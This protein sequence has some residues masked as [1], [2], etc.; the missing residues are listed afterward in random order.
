[1][2]ALSTRTTVTLVLTLVL[3]FFGWH[4]EAHATTSGFLAVSAVTQGEIR[5]NTT[6]KGREGLMRVVAISPELKT[7][8][9]ATTGEATAPHRHRPLRLTI[10]VDNSMPLLMKALVDNELLT[11]VTVRMFAPDRTG[12]ETNHYSIKL[13]NA[14]ITRFA[15]DSNPRDPE[16]RGLDYLH[17]ELTYETIELVWEAGGITSSASWLVPQGLGSRAPKPPRPKP[18]TATTPKPKPKAKAIAKPKRRR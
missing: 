13:V 10:E 17:L 16:R 9:D 8:I 14:H 12:K 4:A 7:P 1:M 6:T 2:N 18:T 3:A 11:R 5:G 15:L